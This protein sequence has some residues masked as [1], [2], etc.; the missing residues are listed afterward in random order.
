MRVLLL[1]IAAVCPVLAHEGE[2]LQPHDVW[3]TWSWDPF[4][5]AGLFLSAFLYWRGDRAGHGIRG[6]ERTA[7]WSGWVSLAVALISPLHPAG[8]VLFSAHMAQH[9]ILMLVSAP[10]LVLGRP[11]VA[12]IWGLP[13]SWRKP[14]GRIS[15][16][17]LV[18]GLWRW[19]TRP[20]NAWW[21]HAIALWAWHAPSLFEMTLKSDF[22]HAMQ[23]LSFLLTALLFWWTLLRG[24]EAS[25]KYGPAVFYV[26]TT[27]V[28][29]SILGAL[30]TFSRVP[31]YASYANTTQAWGLTALEDQQLGGLIM[32]VPAGFVFLAAGLVL[33]AKWMQSSDPATRFGTSLALAICF[34]STNCTLDTQFDNVKRVA[35]ELTGGSAD[36]GRKAIEK[37]GCGACHTIPGVRGANALV[38]PPLNRIASRTYIAGVLTNTPE[39][40]HRWI[41]NPAAVDPLTAM[42]NLG[43]G[44]PDVNDIVTYLYTLK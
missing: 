8:E 35:H 24:R 38:G 25:L 21:I 31:W 12:S 36:R 34:L 4:I 1:F 13:E 29:S 18:S 33:F 44:D 19:L 40:M 27:G 3:T 42:P 39:N 22:V 15:R 20:L 23:H 26:F 32:W 43:I 37:Y 5:V 9:E 2:P 17:S 14:A 10:L 28:H 30:L 11:L 41:R 16:T 7:F 6:W